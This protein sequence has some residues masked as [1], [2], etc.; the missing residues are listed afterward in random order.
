MA[1]IIQLL[2]DHVANQIAAGEVVQRPASAVKE[3][4]ENALDAGADVVRVMIKDAGKTLI[5][6]I[7]NGS[8]MSDTDARMS[9]ERHATSKIRKTE[10]LFQIVTKGFR[11]EALASIAAVAQV[12]L[13]TRLKGESLGTRLLI[14]GSKVQSQETEA[15]AEGT[16]FMVKNLFFN[17]PARRYFLKSDAIEFRHIIDEFQRVALTHP[18]TE[19][20]L[21]HNGS[22]VFSLPRTTLRQRIVHV[23]G[24]RYNEK[25]V[26]VDE[27]TDIVSV[28]G[29]VGKPDTSRKTRGDQFFFINNRFIRNTYL[30]HA[31]ASAFEGL[32][33]TGHHPLYLLYFTID[34][35]QIDVNIHPTKTEVKFQDERAVYAILHAAVKRALGRH[36]IA[37]TL[38]FEQEM[39][40]QV[41]PVR[42]GTEVRP[43]EVQVN[44]DF[45]PFGLPAEERQDAVKSWFEQRENGRSGGWQEMYQ[46]QQELDRR[47][48]LD[49]AGQVRPSWPEIHED[50]SFMQFDRRYILVPSSAGLVLMDQ[51][52]AHERVLYEQYRKQVER[53]EGCS[54]QLLFPES[55]VLSPPEYAMLREHQQEL[56]ALGFDLHF[57]F[58]SGVEITGIPPEVPASDCAKLIQSMA[59]ALAED[60]AR[61]GDELRE[62]MA[63]SLAC[64]SS[65]KYGQLLTIPEMKE[66]AIRLSA[67]NEPWFASGGRPVLI[68]L[69]FGYIDR[70]FS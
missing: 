44:K 27:Y 63:W 4:M 32:V 60:T 23:F 9:F 46:I 55:V 34:P 66:L 36:N 50:S 49:P 42:H 62:R 54:Q 58:A 43:P 28:S 47:P 1:D 65:I 2:P 29:F 33:P 51:Q 10:D 21:V 12:E 3:L 70:Q 8:G 57:D 20:Q 11:G 39:A 14:E 53:G 6:V 41:S 30:H 35:E 25:L 13:R 38:D 61:A 31:V 16:N 19:F 40:I 68:T 26:P 17:V 45:N 22:E 56:A 37:P 24:A 18:D 52:R 59:T 64:G 67:C 15:C 7:D 48:V 5:Q 69:P